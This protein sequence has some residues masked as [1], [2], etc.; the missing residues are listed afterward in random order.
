MEIQTFE[1]KYEN[2]H[3]IVFAPDVILINISIT[4]I[5]RNC[6]VVRLTLNH[7]LYMQ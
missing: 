2:S 3:I 1:A 4:V 7:I 6:N 5:Y